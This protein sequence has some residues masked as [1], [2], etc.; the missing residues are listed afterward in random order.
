M[1]RINI[2]W[3]QLSANG[4]LQ[5][6]NSVTM[7]LK[8]FQTRH[9]KKVAD[10]FDGSLK[11]GTIMYEP[12][13]KVLARDLHVFK[14]DNQFCYR[15]NPIK[16]SC[17]ILRKI[18]LTPKGITRLDLAID[19]VRF[20]YRNTLPED[21]I[22]RFLSG[23]YLK[24]GEM[25]KYKLMGQQNETNHTFD[26]LRFGSNT[27]PVSV[28]M[29][30]KSKEMREVRMKPYICDQWHK[31][32]LSD[33]E[34]DIWRLEITLKGNRMKMI[35]KQTAEI[36][37]V[38]IDT[39]YQ[40]NTILERLFNAI[41]KKYFSFKLN[42][43]KTNKSR[44]NDIILFDHIYHCPDDIV[45]DRDKKDHTRSDKIFIRKMESANNEL[46]QKVMIENNNENIDLLNSG[47]DFLT[48]FIHNRSL[49]EYYEKVVMFSNVN[50]KDTL[51]LKEKTGLTHPV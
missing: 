43:G 51:P 42:D 46:R 7:V 12:H 33:I 17:D 49:V 35:D 22:K 41:I 24:L 50:H 1:K 20:D 31:D 5:A 48:W 36:I 25:R 37:N 38:T 13:S 8:D 26:Y 16:Y 30:N 6:E 3:L 32:G 21:F 9:F 11:I 40:D 29:Y 44:M 10:V 14:L 28:Y 39:L 23:R 15:E 18:G 27:S 4:I 34:E 45:I 19:F 2:D 47:E